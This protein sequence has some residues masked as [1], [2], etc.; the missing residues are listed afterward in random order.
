M[1]RKREYTIYT[2]NAR[3]MLRLCKRKVR[4]FDM[5][6]EYDRSLIVESV[7]TYSESALFYQIRKAIRENG[8]SDS[9]D[10]VTGKLI[11]LHFDN[12]V[13]DSNGKED[14]KEEV[15]KLLD[16]GVYFRFKGDREFRRF[17]PFDKSASMS[18]QNVISFISEDV[19]MKVDAALRLGLLWERLEIEASKYYAYRGLY[20]TDGT[21]IPP[22]AMELNEETVIVLDIETM[23]VHDK[24]LSLKYADEENNR[25][26]NADGKTIVDLNM[27]RERDGFTSLPYDGEGIICPQYAK[28]LNK[29]A[30][31][32]KQTEASSFQIRM[33][34]TKGIQI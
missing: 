25:A 3:E 32:D 18:R 23:G 34:F 21:E 33:P 16:E 15:T 19:F 24:T 17:V 9:P 13:V 5:T 8:G 7:K 29:V 31:E 22:S 28:R 1:K 2:I 27:L 30:I 12:G 26:F 11:Y 4:C 6:S 10:A 20:M 14:I